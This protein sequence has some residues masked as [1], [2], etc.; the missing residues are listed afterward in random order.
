[1][2]VDVGLG[3]GVGVGEAFTTFTVPTMLQHPP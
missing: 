3:V 1:M 2:G